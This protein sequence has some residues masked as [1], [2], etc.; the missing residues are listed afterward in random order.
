MNGNSTRRLYYLLGLAILLV[1]IGGLLA[2]YIQ[3]GGGTIQIKDVR[4]VGT[5]G[6]EMSALLYIP[7]GVTNKTPAPGILAVHGY[8][9]SRETQDGFAIE[10]A[11]RGYVVLALDQTGHGY[12]DPPAFANGFGGPDGLA[13]LR[14]L[15][16]V[17]KDNIGLEGHSMGGW[18]SLAAAGAFQ[19]NY[20]SI[21]IEGSSTGAP[22]AADGTATWP[23]NMALVFSQWDEFSDLMWAVPT[24]KEVVNSDKLKTVFDTTDPVEVGKLYGS[25]AD[26]TARKLYAPAGTHP[27]DHISTE[28]IGYAIDWMQ[29]TLTGGNGLPPSDQVWYWKEIGT[30]IAFI[31]FVLALF[32]VGG[33]LLQAGWFKDLGEPMP[34]AKP[35]KSTL[36]WVGAAIAVV[37]P[38]LTFFWL[39]NQGN[40]WFPAG[41][42]W[43]QTISTGI[44]TWAAGNGLIFL[45]LFLVWH[46]QANRK[47]GAT[48]QTYGV[49]WASGLNWRKI[50]KSLGLAFIIV[51]FGYLLLA[52]SD[53]LF[54]TDFRL[55]VLALKP[56]NFLQFHI[57]LA[58]IIPFAFFFLVSS[59]VLNGEMRQVQADGSPVS[60]RRAM[61]VNAALMA[62]GI[63][64]MLLIQYIPLMAGNPLPLGE[65]LLTIVGIQFV[66]LL[67]IVGLILTYYFRKTGHIYVGAFICAMFITWYIVAGQAIQFAF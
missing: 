46:F 62:L 15:D 36:W 47:A 55:W 10:F 33:L 12:S 58:Y 22:F 50:A 31:G 30:F 66:P 20:K 13:Y 26:G 38:A 11:R 23:R 63:V 64:I 65:S 16:I 3:T 42:F 67:I 17:D 25:I 52:L 5:N 41:A 40:S 51:F 53:W 35:A 44:A 1:L 18:A 8:I 59:M 14:S 48:A 49:S 28:A 37:L 45:V 21:V 7:D 54:K 61:L 43:P 9:N 19:D 4:F 27:N 32:P 57:T 24:G 34:E 29:T 39:Q 2:S 6:T 60:M 56:M